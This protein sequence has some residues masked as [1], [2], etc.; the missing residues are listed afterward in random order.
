MV[1]I[2]LVQTAKAEEVKI[3]PYPSNHWFR[4]EVR[5]HVPPRKPV[6]LLVLISGDIHGFSKALLPPLLASNGVMTLV[7]APARAGLLASEP[8]LEELDAIIGDVLGKFKVAE[9]K[10]AIGG[11]SAGGIG[12]VRYAQFCLKGEA[13]AHTP[14]AVFAVDSPLDYERWYH[15]AELYLQR[16]ALAGRDLAEDRRATNELRT[17]LGGSPTE[18]AD[19]YRRHSP[20]TA[21]L[22]DGGNA[23]LL[24]STPVRIYI[25]PEI[26]WRLEH[27]NREVFHTNIP[28]ATALINILRLLGNTQA[29]LIT[30]SGAGYM[31]DGSRNPHSWSIVDERALAQW[32]IRWLDPGQGPR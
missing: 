12:A 27:W 19:A 10:V 13:K 15:G 9:A 23:R 6:G 2:V 8:M 3:E 25:E 20:L 5:L 7:T 29:E 21:R 17:A 14:V 30:T 18:A 26:R 31:A 4:T 1:A 28:D 11:F 16:L 22:A 24:K 32:L